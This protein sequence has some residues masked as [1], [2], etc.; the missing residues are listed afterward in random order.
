MPCGIAFCAAMTGN[1]VSWNMVTLTR[2]LASIAHMHDSF[3]RARLPGSNKPAK[4]IHRLAKPIVAA[5][6]ADAIVGSVAAGQAT[7]AR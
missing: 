4:I 1:P 3:T 2:I 5:C 6:T 7:V